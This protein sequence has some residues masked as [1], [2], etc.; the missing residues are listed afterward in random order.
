M[1]VCGNIE[2][3]R[4]LFVDAHEEDTMSVV[5]R[6]QTQ[7]GLKYT[8]TTLLTVDRNS[9]SLPAKSR[10]TSEMNKY[11]LSGLRWKGGGIPR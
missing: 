3:R 10:N 5:D 2:P 7:T 11:E 1:S 8:L 9:S 4:Y 6:F